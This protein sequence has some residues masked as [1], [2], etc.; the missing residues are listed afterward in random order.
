MADENCLRSPAAGSELPDPV[1]WFGGMIDHCYDFAE[2]AHAQG[3]PIVGI[4]CEFTPREII[5][6]AGAVPVC[7]CGGSAATIPAA[8]QFLPAN[9][10]PLIKSTFGYQIT[11]KNPFLNWA[12]LVVAETTCDGKKK[13]FELLGE[14][15]PMYVLEL[16]QKAEECDALEHWVLELRKFRQ[17]LGDRYEVDINDDKLRQASELMNRERRLRRQLADLMKAAPPPITGRQLLEFK[18]IISGVE[19]DLQQYERALQMYAPGKDDNGAANQAAGPPSEEVSEGRSDAEV[20]QHA[21]AVRVLLTGV[22]LVHGAER[23]LELIEGCGAVVVCMENC[24]GLKPILED[25][26]LHYEPDPIRAIGQ[27]YYHLPCS[28]MTPNPRRFETLRDLTAKFRPQCVIELVW[29]AC[30]TYDVESW[31]VRKLVEEE[32][33]LHYLKITTDYSPSDSARI[34]GRVEALLEMVRGNGG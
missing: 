27:K 25:V 18:S 9:L 3:R 6:A 12:D 28:V 7:L 16:P 34:T 15:K 30:L 24:T 5:L 19:A 17:F 23:V 10:C 31:K 32:L 20:R 4:M 22:P 8:E 33:H 2:S 29:Q 13:M 14:S 21:P 26:D 1:A 11:G